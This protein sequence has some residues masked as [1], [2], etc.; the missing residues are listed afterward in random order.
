MNDY[1]SRSKLKEFIQTTGDHCVSLYMPT[2]RIGNEA[3]QDPIRL[4]N[5]LTRAEEE[6]TERG[7]RRPDAQSLLAPAQRLIDDYTF[8]QHQS[9]GLAALLSPTESHIHRLP[10]PFEEL[11]VIGEHFHV[12]P[13][14]PLFSNDGRF[15]IL[16]LSQQEVRLLEGT[17]YQVDE[18]SLQDVPTSLAEA[19]WY[20]DKERQLQ[21]HAAAA[22]S[23]RGSGEGVIF[24]GHGV[25][26]DDHKND[27]LRFFQQVD[28]GLNEILGD[29]SIPM[30]L[31]G[32]DYL[33]PIYQ[34]ASTYPHLVTGGIQGNPEILSTQE[35][36]DAGWSIVSPI[37]QQECDKAMNRYHTALAHELA[38]HK[39]REIVPAAHA[40]RVEIAFTALDEQRWG[41]FEQA[42]YSVKLADEATAENEDLLNVV[43]SQ[44]LLNDG[45]VY[46][47]HREDMPDHVQVAALF[48]Y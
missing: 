16:A 26:D 5:L 34:Q 22:A 28:R 7:M 19:L 36:H 9:D 47:L 37:F 20:D 18:V 42:T 6:L 29:E 41:T 31:A 39:L 43:A 10:L 32:V 48:R 13:I 11:L 2:H 4:G 35:L 38:S 3:Q 44:T 45:E 17:R 14:V 1:L 33:Q 30:V 40:G 46:A 25:G 23:Q 21:Q 8:W 27:I 12:K 15:Y 24:H